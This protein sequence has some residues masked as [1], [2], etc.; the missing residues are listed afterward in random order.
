MKKIFNYTIAIILGL[1]L[2]SCDKLFDSLEGDLT[3]MSEE[4]MISST[5]GLE[6]LLSDV[7]NSIPMDA[8]N[9]KDE[10]TT[11]ASYS[12]KCDYSIDVT[13]FWNYT[14]MRSINYFIQQLDE[15]LEKEYIS[16]SERDEMMGEALFARAYCYFAMVRRYGGVPIVTVPLDDKYDGDKN[17]GLYIPRSTEKETW[18]FVISELDKAAELLP[19]DRGAGNYRAT[20]WAALGLQSRVALYAASVSKYWSKETIPSY[21]IDRRS[22]RAS[23][24]KAGIVILLGLAFFL[25]YF[26]ICSETLGYGTPKEM[27]LERRNADLAEEIAL[28]SARV[29][30]QD[31]VLT[32]LSLRDNLVRDW[33]SKR[34]SSTAQPVNSVRGGI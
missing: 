4:D 30:E 34:A 9:T 32:S 7:Y 24:L 31:E 26:F 11:L 22:I 2:C 27:L 19:E 33:D 13:G 12:K 6:R 20:K 18:D 16:Q 29:E 21:E 3:R 28:L 1:G 5:A 10:N 15:A 17:E 8:F 25:L 23:L 14:K